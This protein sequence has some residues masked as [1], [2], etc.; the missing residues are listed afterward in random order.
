MRERKKDRGRESECGKKRDCEGNRERV[1]R[2]REKD[3]ESEGKRERVR[4]KERE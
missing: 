1:R 2:V 3:R 4:E